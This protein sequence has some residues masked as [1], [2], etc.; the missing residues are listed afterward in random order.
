MMPMANVLLGL[1]SIGLRLITIGSERSFPPA[2]PLPGAW[3]TLRKWSYSRLSA[4]VAPTEE[5]RQW[6]LEHTTARRVEVI[7]NPIAW[8]FVPQAP[9]MAPTAVGYAGR[10]R[11]LAVGRLGEEKRFANLIEVFATL[12]PDF[13]GWEL[14]VLG[15]GPQRQSLHG[16]IMRLGLSDVVFL[17]GHVGN[18]GDW[19]RSADLFALTSRFEGFPNVLL[20]ALAHG[21]PAVSVDCDTG[22]R[23]IIRPGVDGM[24]VPPEDDVALAVAL[25]GLMGSE[26]VRQH[27]G[28]RAAEALDRFSLDRIVGPWERLLGGGQ[29]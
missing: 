10:R 2:L 14:V 5:I 27:L 26:D 12:L 21:L 23:D 17:P 20:E 25:R 29:G 15:D 9:M 13:P 1:A 6:L 8:P 19:Y 4:V 24:L 18:L 16:L 7:P 22:P 3:M 28:A 11:L